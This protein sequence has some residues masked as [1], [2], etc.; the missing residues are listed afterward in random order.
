MTNLNIVICDDET[1]YREKLHKIIKEC[2]NEA[3]IKYTISEYESGDELC[4][5]L[6]RIIEFNVFF[7]D[8]SMEGSDGIKTAALIRRYNEEAII[9]FVT[10]LL[11]Y[12]REGYK[13]GAFRYLFKGEDD[14]PK[15]VRMELQTI[16]SLLTDTKSKLTIRFREGIYRLYPDDILLV[17]SKGHYLIYKVKTDAGITT[18]SM[19]ERLDRIW[20]EYCDYDFVR[21]HKSYMVNM[22]HISDCSGVEVT[23]SDGTVCPLSRSYRKEFELSYLKYRGRI[24]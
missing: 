20:Q 9:V 1:D 23:L 8:I 3:G 16:Y 14:N 13:V 7:L 19:R 15:N 24:G 4:K 12:S 17:E 18:Y 5:D 11:E 21:I 6:Q 10:S 22:K 2:L